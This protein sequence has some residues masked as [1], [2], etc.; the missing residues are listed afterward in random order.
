MSLNVIR[1]EFHSIEKYIS[2]STI[3]SKCETAN[4]LKKYDEET[5]KTPEV[6]QTVTHLEKMESICKNIT[7]I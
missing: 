1:E 4:L 3:L 6:Y 5:K 7:E 2:D